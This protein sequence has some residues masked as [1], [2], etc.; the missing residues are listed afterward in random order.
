MS[1]LRFLRLCSRA[2]RTRIKSTMAFRE[3]GGMEVPSIS[4]RTSESTI[5]LAGSPPGRPP[6]L[7]PKRVD[8][9]EP[10]GLHGRVEAEEEA[11]GRRGAEREHDPPERQ[12]EAE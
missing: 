9:V 6:S 4:G 2:P 8:R 10:R 5:R 12:R 11:D 1:R 7:V 3:M